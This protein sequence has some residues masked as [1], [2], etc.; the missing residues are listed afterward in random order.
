MSKKEYDTI[1]AEILA[2]VAG[3]TA[4]V[5]DKIRLAT[6]MSNDPAVKQARTEFAREVKDARTAAF[7]AITRNEAFDYM[8]RNLSNVG[9]EGLLTA[10]SQA[11]GEAAGSTS[12]AEKQVAP[13]IHLKVMLVR[14]GEPVKDSTGKVTGT[15]WIDARTVRDFHGAEFDEDSD[16][17][18]ANGA[19]EP[20]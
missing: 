15:N 19:T 10:L 17:S 11:N 13:G 4:T 5:A 8:L 6:L 20:Q 2:K 12:L 3:G 18:T 14:E 1:L 7:G 16:D 9:R